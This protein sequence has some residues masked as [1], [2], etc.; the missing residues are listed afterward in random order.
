MNQR[1]RSN[2]GRGKMTHLG[3]VERTLATCG[4]SY[5]RTRKYLLNPVD[6]DKGR[7]IG[8][9]NEGFEV[10]GTTTNDDILLG[11]PIYIYTH[12]IAH[13]MRFKKQLDTIGIIGPSACN[14][15]I[16]LRCNLQVGDMFSLYHMRP[17][18]WL[19]N[20]KAA[21]RCRQW[22]THHNHNFPISAP[23]PRCCLSCIPFSFRKFQNCK[24]R[25]RKPFR[26]FMTQQIEWGDKIT[27]QF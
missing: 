25:R 5:E 16:W 6:F 20:C 9:T 1:C 11:E 23:I 19:R 14:S 15:R 26:W 10:K 3:S 17:T 13:R 21:H 2:C 24:P 22:F 4:D 18:T 12:Y 27:G 7:R 8:A